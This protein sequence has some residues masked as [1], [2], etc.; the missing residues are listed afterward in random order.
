M[1]YTN[2]VF[3]IKLPTGEWA[4]LILDSHIESHLGRIELPAE[5]GKSNILW[6]DITAVGEFKIAGQSH[7]GPPGTWEWRE[8][9]RE[10]KHISSEAPG[11]YP[12]IY[13]ANGVL[14]IATPEHNGSQGWR[15]VAEDGTLITG[16]DT[17]NATRRIGLELGLRDFWE[18]SYLAGVVI[19]QGETG[20]DILI[21]G[22]RRRLVTG[23]A[24]N[25]RVRY[26]GVWA[27][28]LYLENERT[29]Y[30]F[31]LTRTELSALPALD[32]PQPLGDMMIRSF[33]RPV[34]VAPFFSHSLRYGD[35]PDH[36]GNAIWSPSEEA[37]R[38]AKFGVPMITAHSAEVTDPA[39]VN[40]TIGWWVSGA[41]IGELNEAVYRAL[42]STEKPVIAYLDQQQA[43]N[44]E[45]MNWSHDRVWPSVQAYRN[46]GEPLADFESRVQRM[47]DALIAK[48]AK[49]LALTPAFFTRN[50]AVSVDHILECMPLY[51]KWINN[52][53]II[54]F[55]PF[56]DRR[57]TGMLEHPALRE[58]AKAFFYAAP[59]G[60]PNRFD[61]W[62]GAESDPV[63]VLKNKLGQTRSAVVLE[64]ELRAFIL[65]AIEH[66]GEVPE[67][68]EPEN[69]FPIV[70][71]VW[72]KYGGAPME[73]RG[74]MV[75]EI[76]WIG[77]G[78]KA[79]GPWGMSAKPSGASVE[80]PHTG[81]K[82]A[83]DIV[84]HGPTDPN[85]GA[86]TMFDVFSDTAPTWGEAHPHNNPARVWVKPVKP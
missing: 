29:S 35:T 28:S 18:Y 20:C 49:Y 62:K 68:G 47:L 77:N 17:L 85:T 44:W 2:A 23:A 5:G 81:I 27:I 58:W 57:P 56:A 51:E 10:W 84:Q 9:T 70:Q 73:K 74:A 45:G 80:Q 14:H 64:P 78:N 7:T 12:C 83:Q 48:G 63:T 1:K 42:E 54:C 25:I 22:V 34:W 26:N 79:D 15:Y 38:I 50:G 13:D 41:N 46:A 31:V 40:L 67:P 4:N 33:E 82:I 32:V 60:R 43:E 3:H 53:P 65:E 86:A 16:D 36:V 76:A 66:G 61:Y 21:D 75:N 37:S 72:D 59:S 39:A 6:L 11:V 71:K 24:K 55:M 69:I 30:D 19:G 52:Y 8:S